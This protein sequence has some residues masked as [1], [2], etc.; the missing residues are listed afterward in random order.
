MS[1][2]PIADSDTLPDQAWLVGLLSL[3]KLGPRRLDALVDLHG[4]PRNVWE[5]IC[6]GDA[7]VRLPQTSTAIIEKWTTSAREF[8]C[9]LYT[10]D[11]ADE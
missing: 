8:S 3:P 2:I 9:L 5:K 11:A 4:S 1:T 6:A 10:S 7:S